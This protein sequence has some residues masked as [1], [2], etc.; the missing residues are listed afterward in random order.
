MRDGL[1]LDQHLR[2]AQRGN[3]HQRGGREIALEEFLPRAPDFG[4]LP[5]VDHVNR[6][7]RH[8]VHRPARG[9]DQV[10][11][12]GEDDLRLLVLA[13]TFDGLAVVRA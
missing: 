1:D 9:L 11:D 12:L 4:V 3:L 2:R 6:H 8:V 10:L 5:D 7:P 13:F